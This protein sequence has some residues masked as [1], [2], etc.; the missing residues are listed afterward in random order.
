VVSFAPNLLIG[1]IYAR[2]TRAVTLRRAFVLGH[3]MIAW[4][5]IGYIAVWR[6]ISRMLRGVNNWDKT[7]RTH[8]PHHPA[9]Q[10]LPAA[11]RSSDPVV[12]RLQGTT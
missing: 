6:A 9:N 11:T 3:L 4:N 1:F 2:R 7:T 10:L 8:E 5:Y 12:T